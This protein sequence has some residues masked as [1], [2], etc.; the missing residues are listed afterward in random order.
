MTSS[1]K[2]RAGAWGSTMILYASYVC[3]LHSRFVDNHPIDLEATNPSFLRWFCH[4]GHEPMLMYNGAQVLLQVPL[5][6]STHGST[7]SWPLTG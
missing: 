2:S 3:L 7:R 5:P 1:K 4:I 6:P